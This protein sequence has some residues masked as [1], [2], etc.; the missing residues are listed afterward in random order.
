MPIFYDIFLEVN[1]R[2]IHL[3]KRLVWHRKKRLIA[4]ICVAL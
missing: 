3:K 2:V 4:Y 1:K